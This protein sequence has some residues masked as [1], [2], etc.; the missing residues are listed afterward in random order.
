MV[1]V[2]EELIMEIVKRDHEGDRK[3][4]DL[5]A[6]TREIIQENADLELENQ[7]LS[8]FYGQMDWKY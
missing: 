1:K 4:R 8:D 5:I 2:H 6:Q 3:M 7:K